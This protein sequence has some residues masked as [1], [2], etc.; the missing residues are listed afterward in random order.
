[1]F[2]NMFEKAQKKIRGLQSFMPEKRSAKMLYT[3]Q[4][5]EK[6]ISLLAYFFY[7]WMKL[8]PKPI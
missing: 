7:F 6:A 4:W 1:M 8:R 2:K 5:L 3:W